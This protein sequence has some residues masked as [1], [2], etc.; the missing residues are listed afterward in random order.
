MMLML[1][2]HNH[3]GKDTS[4]ALLLVLFH[5]VLAAFFHFLL[6]LLQHGEDRGGQRRFAAFA[7]GDRELYGPAIQHFHQ[8]LVGR[9]LILII[10]N[11]SRTSKN[12]M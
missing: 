8:T 2:A 11:W 7:F 6:Q 10:L 3:N 1:N 12:T 9:R 5:Q 4:R